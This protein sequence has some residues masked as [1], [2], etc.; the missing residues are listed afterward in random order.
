M[1]SMQRYAMSPQ[2]FIYHLTSQSASLDTFIGTDVSHTTYKQGK[3]IAIERRVNYSPIVRIQFDNNIHV[4]NIDS[5][6][7]GVFD[8]IGIP[9]LADELSLLSHFAIDY[10]YHITH[11]KNL[12]SI[13]RNG[14]MPRK[15][16]NEFIEIL[17]I[18]D[19]E[20]NSRRTRKVSSGSGVSRSLHEYVPLYFNPCNPMLSARREIQNELAILAVVADV[21][22]T[23]DCIFTDGNAASK[24]TKFYSEL[25]DLKMLDWQ[26]LRAKMWTDHNDGKRKRCSEV[27]A[28]P[29]VAENEIVTVICNNSDLYRQIKHLHG[30]SRKVEIRKNLFFM[31]T[32]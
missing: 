9:Q 30:R 19:P 5:F 18:A 29:K 7:L 31:E 1:F 17:D 13:F 11:F 4:F 8:Y 2:S 12:D 14:I 32:E 23:K 20:V 10:L 16:D 25:D 6:R 3:I 22:L 21:L 28:F 24:E 15:H 26:C 27:L